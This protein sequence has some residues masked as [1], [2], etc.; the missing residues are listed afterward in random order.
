MENFGTQ[1]KLWNVTIFLSKTIKVCN[2]GRKKN[3][4]FCCSCSIY[5]HNP[6][7]TQ[8]ERDDLIFLNG[9]RPQSYERERQTKVKWHT[10]KENPP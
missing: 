3:L 10:F 7:P 5:Y 9:R 2:S 8:N 1:T 4:V 6:T